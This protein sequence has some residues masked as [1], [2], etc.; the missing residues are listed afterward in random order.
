ML[1]DQVVSVWIGA[2]PHGLATVQVVTR[3]AGGERLVTRER[4]EESAMR[5]AVRKLAS[6]NDLVPIWDDHT[7]LSDGTRRPPAPFYTT[8]DLVRLRHESITT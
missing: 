5:N 8:R 7:W 3:S 2:A 1:D 4:G 6:Q